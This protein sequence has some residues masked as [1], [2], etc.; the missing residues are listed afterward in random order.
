LGSFRRIGDFQRMDV[1][2]ADRFGSVRDG[3][4]IGLRSFFEVAQP[5]SEDKGHAD[6]TAITPAVWL[7]ARVKEMQGTPS[8]T[9]A[10]VAPMDLDVVVARRFT[11]DDLKKAPAKAR[12]QMLHGLRAHQASLYGI[13]TMDAYDALG[14]LYDFVDLGPGTDPA[15]LRPHQLTHKRSGLLFLRVRKRNDPLRSFEGWFWDRLR[16]PSTKA[17]PRDGR[18]FLADTVT[19]TGVYLVRARPLIEPHGGLPDAPSLAVGF[20][21]LGP[22]WR[23]AVTGRP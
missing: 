21:R 10:T 12:F 15:S 4:A 1:S 11:L 13:D 9:L 6:I 8:T 3:S 14:V 20:A 7:A 16:H 2:V 18:L 23:V 17:T 5:R 19:P 22:H